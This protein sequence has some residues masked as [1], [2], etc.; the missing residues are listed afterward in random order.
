[1]VAFLISFVVNAQQVGTLNNQ[2]SQDGW[3][4]S[5]YGNNSD[6]EIK[7]TIIQS[8][9]KLL[10]CAEAKLTDDGYQ[11]VLI[12][13]NTDGT[14]D[15]T[16]GGGDGIVRSKEDVLLNMYSRAVG[17]VLQNDGKI[18]IAG[19]N[20]NNSERIFRLNPNG[21]IDLT[22]GINGIV[23]MLRPNAER[24]YHIAVQSD[25]KIIVSGRDK[26]I[27]DG[28]ITPHIF[29]WRFTPSGNL[30]S[31]FGNDGVVCYNFVL[32]SGLGENYLKNNNLIILADDKIVI[33][34]TFAGVAGYN[35]MFK[36]LN[37]NGSPDFNYGI[38]GNAIR[39]ENFEDG[40]S[41]YSS[42]SLQ[43]DESIVFSFTSFEQET[44][45]SESIFRLTSEGSFD[46]SLHIELGNYSQNPDPVKVIVNGNKIYVVKR[47]NADN[48]SFNMIQCYDL[49]GTI[50]TEF[51]EN[52]TAV[53]DQNNI[54]ISQQAEAIISED[55]A[56]YLSTH[57]SDSTSS[58]ISMFLISN[59]IGFDSNLSVKHDTK[60]DIILAPNP[61]SGLVNISNLNTINIDKIEIVDIV[62]KAISLNPI[63]VETL[64]FSN[65]S[66][67]VY[68]VKLYSG[69]SVIEKKIVKK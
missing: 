7:K 28:I 16:F 48:S 66:S 44:N 13:Y 49:T 65:Y 50:I 47:E 4:A 52:G 38:N 55:G 14:I 63:E 21:S 33:N 64:D 8:D 26:R 31:S 45:Y 1:M 17:M 56:I 23:D 36:K 2:F 54:P 69:P 41:R 18:L 11:A 12:R 62:G 9:G 57:V 43:Q 35:V 24:I 53:I 32:W 59:I 34:Q 67:G 5:I 20:L 15:T 61:T 42:S 10:V 46:H 6:F 27:V 22:F 3:D 25:N 58:D 39:I 40:I 30:D 37:S 60:N 51:G 19:N 68:V 29:L